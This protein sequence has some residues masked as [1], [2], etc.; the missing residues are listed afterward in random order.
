M[1]TVVRGVRISPELW[2]I[3][4]VLADAL[5]TTRNELVVGVLENYAEN[6]K[7]CLDKMKKE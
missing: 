7:K 3:L 4:Q 6:F 5:D 2:E 1:K